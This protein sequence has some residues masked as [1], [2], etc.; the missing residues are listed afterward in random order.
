MGSEACRL[1]EST[2]GAELRDNT[3]PRLLESPL[4]PGIAPGSLSSSQA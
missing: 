3:G 4:A 2:G 1:E